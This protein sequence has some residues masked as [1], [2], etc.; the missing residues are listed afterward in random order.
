MG[1]L[2]GNPSFLHT[3]STIDLQRRYEA[4]SK[5]LL[6]LE[7]HLTTLAEYFK[8]QRI[9][10]GMR[11]QPH[12]N[13]FSHDVDFRARYEQISNKYS[14]DLIL[15]QLEFLQR[16]V[17]VSKKK[18]LDL[19]FALKEHLLTVD[20]EKL[21]CKQDTFLTKFRSEQEDSK[22]LKWARDSGDYDNGKVYRWGIPTVQ[23][24]R[25]VNRRMRDGNRQT[26][27]N[28]DINADISTVPSTD[29]ADF[30]GTRDSFATNVPE[31]EGGDTNGFVRTRGQR[32]AINNKTMPSKQN[33]SR[34][35]TK[36]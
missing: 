16:D 15:L 24:K 10:R 7:L 17:G 2:D 32:T 18:L 3:P 30:L 8:H 34:K 31:E 19:D 29:H 14:L 27:K 5:R 26:D 36:N 21:V 25:P 28:V 11:I 12:D 33:P 23:N 6:S 4:E 35:I 9:P 1:L 13:S 22:R 20:Y